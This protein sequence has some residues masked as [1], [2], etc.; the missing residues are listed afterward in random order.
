[1]LAVVPS[2]EVDAVGARVLDGAEA[3]GEIRAVLERLEGRF[4]EGG[5]RWRRGAASGS[6]SRRGRREVARRAPTGSHD[7]IL[8]DLYEG[9]HAASQRGDDPFYGPGCARAAGRRCLHATSRGY[10]GAS[11]I[12]SISILGRFSAASLRSKALRALPRSVAPETSG[13]RSKA[14]RALPRSVAPE[15]SGHRALRASRLGHSLPRTRERCTDQ[16]LEVRPV[17][18]RE[19]LVD[20][21]R[22]LGF[23]EAEG[24]QRL[25]R[26][27]HSDD[28]LELRTPN[29]GRRAC[30]ARLK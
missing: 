9:P 4:G 7:A 29:G 10:V 28:A 23:L 5:Y 17:D 20:I 22:S 8:L 21:A 1:M 12:D 18:R 13:H 27:R 14:L 3:L 16:Q 2:E 24:R 6:W 11:K 25:L 15:T 26:L 19:C 30:D